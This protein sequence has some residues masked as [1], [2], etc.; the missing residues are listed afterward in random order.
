MTL[1]W[2]L[3]G[4]QLQGVSKDFPEIDPQTFLIFSLNT[5]YDAWH[6]VGIKEILA[7]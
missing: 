4:Q 1:C 6:I 7:Q 5:K 2:E 3:Q